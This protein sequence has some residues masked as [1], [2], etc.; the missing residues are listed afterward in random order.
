[1][2]KQNGELPH[3]IRCSVANCAYNKD[4]KL[5]E[6]KEIEVGNE[7]AAR[8]SETMCSTYIDR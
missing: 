7:Y 2:R 1:L 3:G 4:G 6:A 5:C 8:P